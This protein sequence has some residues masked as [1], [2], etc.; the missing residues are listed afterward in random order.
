MAQQMPPG[1]YSSKARVMETIVLQPELLA[2]R[3]KAYR[4]RTVRTIAGSKRQI[5]DPPAQQE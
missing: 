1:G 4:R 3:V 2:D 5:F